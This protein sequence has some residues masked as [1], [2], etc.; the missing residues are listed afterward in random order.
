MRKPLSICQEKENPN[1][2]VENVRDF[3][4]ENAYCAIS[5]QKVYGH[6]FFFEAAGTD[7]SYL[8]MCQLWF[9]PQLEQDI[10]GLIFQQDGALPHYHLDVRKELNTRFPSRWIV[11]AGREDIECLPWPPRSPDLTP[12]VFFSGV[13]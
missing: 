6:F 8:D 3:P 13:L 5:H 2:Y 1:I 7:N 9:I 10:E 11:R 4:K 12:C